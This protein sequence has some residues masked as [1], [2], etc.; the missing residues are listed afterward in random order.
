MPA[1]VPC[2]VRGTAGVKR[3]VARGGALYRAA[4]C[5]G[6]RIDV[7]TLKRVMGTHP[8]C[9]RTEIARATAETGG[10]ERKREDD[11]VT[12]RSR[13]FR[14]PAYTRSISPARCRRCSF[15]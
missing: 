9:H 13:P 8:S 5:A 12:G 14:L 6:V 10:A 4:L 15:T 3:S 11:A 7:S 2:A 1:P